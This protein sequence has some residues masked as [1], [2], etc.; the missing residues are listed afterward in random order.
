MKLDG[1]LFVQDTRR[2]DDVG[3]VEIDAGFGLPVYG[4]HLNTPEFK[5]FTDCTAK[6]RE[7]QLQNCNQA[8]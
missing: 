7:K 5:D 3:D 2:R 8:L 1:L 4:F 6:D